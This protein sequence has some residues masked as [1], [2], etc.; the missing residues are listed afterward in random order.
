LATGQPEIAIADS[1]PDS[2]KPI[3]DERNHTRLC[4]PSQCDTSQ[5]VV[6]ARWTRE[7]KRSD[8]DNR[9]TS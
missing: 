8:G 3:P 1:L 5:T 2:L 7:N 9:V 6:G 4:R